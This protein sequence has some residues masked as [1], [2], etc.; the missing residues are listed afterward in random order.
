MERQGGTA[1]AG[2][3]SSSRSRSATTS[4]RRVELN[5]ALIRVFDESQVYRIDHY[6]GKE[7]VRNLLVF[8]FGNG[9]FEPLWNRR[10]VDHVQITVAEDLGVEGR[11]EFYEEA[12][13]SRDILQNHLLQLLTPGR[14]GAADRVRG[15]RAARREGARAARRRHATGPRRACARNVVRGAVHRGLGRRPARAR[16]PR[17]GG[18]LARPPTSR[19]SWR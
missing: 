12:G 5:D 16:L 17:G 10:Y 1:R 14:D 9:I 2:R 15:G 4:T 13:A 11:G 18:G 8:R 7:T 6:L 19:R 3:A